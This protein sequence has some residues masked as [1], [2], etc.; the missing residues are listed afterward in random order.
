MHVC[1]KLAYGSLSRVPVACFDLREHGIDGTLPVG[2]LW[3]RT[4]GL[5]LPA[6]LT[7]Y[8]EQITKSFGE[9]CIKVLAGP[10]GERRTI[11]VGRYG[12]LQ[13]FPV[14]DCHGEEVAVGNIV[15]G[16]DDNSCFSRIGRDGGIEVSIFAGSKGQIDVREVTRPVRPASEIDRTR[17]RKLLDAGAYRTAHNPDNRASMQKSLNLFSCE[18]AAADDEAALLEKVEGDWVR[19]VGHVLAAGFDGGANQAAPLRPGTVIVAGVAISEQLVEHEPRMGATL[20]DSAVRDDG[21]V[22]SYI[23][24][25]VNGLQLGY[26]FEGAVLGDCRCPANVL[27]SRNVAASLGALLGQVFGGKQLA[28]VLSRA[29]NVD[30]RSAILTKLL[31]DLMAVGAN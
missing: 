8:F 13:V 15:H 27:R 16:I 17:T 12:H 9:R 18:L 2:I 7:Q 24:P 5:D 29:A 20:A 26:R 11:A 3:D 21:F 10:A 23:L 31:L 4:L 19:G 28:A 22:C 25:C 1:Q 30:E 14:G 6:N